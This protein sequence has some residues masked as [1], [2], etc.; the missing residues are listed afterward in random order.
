MLVAASAVLLLVTLAI[1][2]ACAVWIARHGDLGAGAAGALALIAGITAT[3]AGVAHRKPDA[4]AGGT[5]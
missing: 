1:G 4:P 3:L 2:L 5:P